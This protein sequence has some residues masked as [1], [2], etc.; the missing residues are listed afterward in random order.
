MPIACRLQRPHRGRIVRRAALAA[1]LLP[2]AAAAQAA[3][4][5]FLPLEEE[6]ALALE[7]APP[8]LRAGA[9]VYALRPD[10]FALVR[11]S[12]NGFTCAVNRDH[13]LAR[14]PTCWDAEGSRTILPKVLWFGEQLAR[15]VPLAEIERE[16]EAGFRS[17]RFRPPARPGVAYM[18]SPRIRNVNHAT[19]EFRSFPPHVM[20]YA[21]GLTD[22]DIGAADE[23]AEGLPFIDYAGP[24]GYM[25]VMPH[26]EAAAAPP[27]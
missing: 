20:F 1:L 24:H 6:V 12:A 9:G 26:R 15:G 18:L 16:V 25:I 4:V 19:G 13:P 5:D 17:G 21:P 22:A 11:P 14:K 27:P 7:A 3:P 8:H 23:V 10:G 2:A